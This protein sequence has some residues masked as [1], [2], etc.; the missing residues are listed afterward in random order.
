MKQRQTPA[1]P[2]K[3]A[4]SQPDTVRITHHI[5]EALELSEINP[6]LSRLFTKPLI[7]VSQP[8]GSFFF[9]VNREESVRCNAAPCLSLHRRRPPSQ[10]RF[11]CWTLDLVPWQLCSSTHSLICT[12]QTA[13]LYAYTPKSVQA[14][15]NPQ[16]VA[17]GIK[18]TD[19]VQAETRDYVI[20]TY[21]LMTEGAD[22][23]RQRSVVS[24]STECFNST[25]TLS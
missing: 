3:L 19:P 22:C 1:E 15:S 20:R 14:G 18:I 5:Q 21:L 10:G 12:E 2:K 24:N 17:A 25:A 8:L 9:E 6:S 7:D 13:L 11:G 23:T 16:A 4:I